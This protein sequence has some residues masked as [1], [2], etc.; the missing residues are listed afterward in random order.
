MAGRPANLRINVTSDSTQATQDLA[1]LE[2]DTVKSMSGLARTAGAAA[3]AAGVAIG[4]ALAEGIRGA[5]EREQVGATIAAQLGGTTQDAKR[6]GKLASKLY[7]EGLVE[8]MATAGQAIRKVLQEGIVQEGPASERALEG[9]S[10][11][12]SDLGTAFGEDVGAVT[13]AVGQLMRTGLA[14]DADH[15]L[16]LITTGLTGVANRSDDLLDTVNEYSTQWRDLGLTGEQALG[17]L[18]QGL[19]NGARDSDIVADALKELNIRVKD[20]SASDALVKLGLDAEALADAFA[21]GGQPAADGLDKILDAIRAIKDPSEQSATAVELLGTQSEDMSAALLG[22]D[23]STAVTEI[24]NVGGAAQAVGDTLKNTTNT[25]LQ[26]FIRRLKE[27]LADAALKYALPALRELA[28][29]LT[30]GLDPALRSIGDWFVDVKNKAEPLAEFFKGDEGLNAQTKKLWENLQELNRNLGWFWDLLGLILIILGG[31]LLVTLQSLVIT[32]AFITGFLSKIA[33]WIQAV[34]D[35]IVKPG[36]QGWLDRLL[37]VGEVLKTIADWI[38]KIADFDIGGILNSLN[39]LNL[40]SSFTVAGDSSG[41]AFAAFA[42]ADAPPPVSLRTQTT[43]T[44]L[45]DGAPIRA[46]VRQQVRSAMTADGARYLAGG[47]A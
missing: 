8:D 46:T 25:E 40:A 12:V 16:D 21:S 23:L 39:P 20:K 9:I 27:E 7:S 34:Y 3:A 18:T 28:T 41:G 2:R 14:R 31:G 24:G 38:K 35:W 43:V 45:L 47:W 26:V 15:A 30:E 4:A 5:I 44:V 29:F 1:N 22:L 6:Y 19:K 13:R 37:S 36:W 33:G 10:R 17:L 11:K 32:L 42:A